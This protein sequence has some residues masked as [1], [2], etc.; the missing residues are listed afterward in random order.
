[1]HRR[2]LT[3]EVNARI[4]ELNRLAPADHVPCLV[5]CECG[6]Q[7]CTETIHVPLGI[8]EA[9]SMP[10]RFLLRAGHED[11]YDEVVARRDGF[12]VVENRI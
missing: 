4:D 10:G 5:L 12:V 9:R 8:F 11:P 6:G 3:H 2:A 7:T 1:M